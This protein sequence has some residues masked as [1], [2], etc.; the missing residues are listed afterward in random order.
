VGTCANYLLLACLIKGDGDL[1]S[2]RGREQLGVH[3]EG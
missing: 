2:C 1:F 3:E